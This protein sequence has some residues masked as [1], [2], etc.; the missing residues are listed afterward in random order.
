MSEKFEETAEV[1][2]IRNSK[3]KSC[4]RKELGCD[5]D[6]GKISVVICDTNSP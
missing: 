2:R 5:Y 4:I 1:N 3:S 6:K